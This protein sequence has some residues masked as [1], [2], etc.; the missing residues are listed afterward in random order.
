VTEEKKPAGAA[1]LDQPLVPGQE[2]KSPIDLLKEKIMTDY[3][4]LGLDDTFRFA[5]H[6][7]VACF[8]KCCADVNIFLT[9]Y[10]VLRLKNA[11]GMDST[12]FLDR[13]TQIPIEKNQRY[14]VVMLKM[15]E[16]NDRRCYFVS[17]DG[18]TVYHDRPWPCRMY[19]LGMASPKDPDAKNFFFL[20][21]EDVCKGFA[22]GEEWTV[23]S[24]MENQGVA[25]YEEF[26]RLYKE[27]TLHDYF[28]KG[29]TLTPDKMEMF[30]LAT[31]DL[32]R[33][34]RFIFESSF[35]KRFQVADDTL[36]VIKKDDEALLRWGFQWLKF[37]LFGEPTIEIRPEAMGPRNVPPR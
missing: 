11:V 26:G 15:D 32:D 35:L 9:P 29:K 24:W 21:K 3:D 17:E 37:S 8:N 1:R 5:C 18:C 27:I 16:D 2:D 28:G 31:Y 30:Y 23:K 10:D 36:A 4:R 22:E 33:F 12:E 19:P 14:P 34:R 20:M 7:D 6:K 25:N 13:Y